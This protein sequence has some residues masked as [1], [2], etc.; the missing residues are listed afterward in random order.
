MNSNFTNESVLAMLQCTGTGALVV[1]P[2]FSPFGANV[3]S[4]RSDTLEML[5]TKGFG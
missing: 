3:E 5:C 2:F 4:L 1:Q